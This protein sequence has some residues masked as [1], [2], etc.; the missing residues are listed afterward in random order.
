MC[1]TLPGTAALCRSGLAVADTA[2]ALHAE[3]EVGVNE[4]IA[5]EYTMSYM[6]HAMSSYFNRDNVALPGACC[7]GT[8]G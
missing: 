4:Q 1:Q 2:A 8:A 6:Y 7:Q 5:H 3:S